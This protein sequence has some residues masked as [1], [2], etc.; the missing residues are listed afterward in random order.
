MSEIEKIYFETNEPDSL[1]A[2]YRQETTKFLEM[3]SDTQ[4]LCCI[5]TIALKYL[6]KR[7]MA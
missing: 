7:G 1:N 5:Y 3:I 4:F 2:E 6:K